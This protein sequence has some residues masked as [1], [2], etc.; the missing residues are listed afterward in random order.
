MAMKH[1]IV[2]VLVRCW[3]VLQPVV[4]TQFFQTLMSDSDSSR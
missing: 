1:L 3:S 4:L 2:D